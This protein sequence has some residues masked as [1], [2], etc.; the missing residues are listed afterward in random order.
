VKHST[1]EGAGEVYR[2]RSVKRPRRTRDEVEGV[3]AAMYSLLEADHP[4]TVRQV[5]YQLVSHGVIA[6]TEQEYKNTVVA[7]LTQMRRAR[8]LPFGWIADNTRWMRKPDTHR[9]LGDFLEDSQRFYR[10]ALWN[11]QPVYVEIWLEKDALSGV[12]M[13]ETAPWDVPLMVTRGYPSL[14][15][16]WSAAEMIAAH[17]KPAFLYYFGDHDPS[18]VDI[19]RAVERGIR[20]FAPDADIRFE[21]VAVTPWQIEG[22]KLPTRPT[23]KSDSRSRNFAGES[24]EVD[25]IPAPILR[26]L[27]KRCIEGHIDQGAL[28]KTQRVEEAERDTLAMFHDMWRRDAAPGL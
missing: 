13:Q 4:M 12:V 23:K 27:V 15:F 10:R 9:S 28:E 25:A 1:L 16:L 17:E 11:D 22:L 21:R 2:S 20:E 8:R 5:F 6:K 24:V 14:S 26:L 19:T 18:G 3:R 7:Q